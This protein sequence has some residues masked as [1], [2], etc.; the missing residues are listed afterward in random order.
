MKGELHLPMLWGSS[1]KVF[2][3]RYID[4]PVGM[5]GVKM[6]MEIKKWAAIDIPTRD[7]DVPPVDVMTRGLR[8]GV[9]LIADGEPLYVGCMGGVGRTGLYMAILAKAWGVKDPVKYVRDQ[10]YSHAVETKQQMEYVEN[11]VIPK[12]VLRMIR[13]MK[14]RNVFKVRK[15]LTVS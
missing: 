5:L 1:Y 12:D 10:Y 9:K 14:L 7:Y 2:G 3:G 4:K 11:F 13:F 8:E 15:S 6:A